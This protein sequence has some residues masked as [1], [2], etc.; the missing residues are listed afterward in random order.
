MPH[1]RR[2]RRDRSGPYGQRDHRDPRAQ[3]A[4]GA[5]GHCE[6]RGRA[7]GPSVASSWV[8]PLGWAT[9]PGVLGSL[10]GDGREAAQTQAVANDEDARERHR[11][12]SLG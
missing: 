1:D 2:G 8:S 6:A 11:R 5:R 9:G 3:C 10:L 7:R 4:R 12:R